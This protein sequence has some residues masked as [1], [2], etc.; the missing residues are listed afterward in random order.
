MGGYW[1]RLLGI[2]AIF[3]CIGCSTSKHIFVKGNVSD[4]YPDYR[5]LITPKHKFRIVF[6][7]KDTIV[8]AIQKITQDS[9]MLEPHIK[10][11]FTKY[12]LIDVNKIYRKDCLSGLGQGILSGAISG[13]LL[14]GV[15]GYSTVPQDCDPCFIQPHHTGL[16]S[17][18]IGAIIGGLF[19]GIVGYHVGDKI[20]FEVHS[21]FSDK[22]I[23]PEYDIN[24]P[25]FK[26]K[27]TYE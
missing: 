26:K 8:G 9:L 27:K 6:S 16:I 5:K 23:N 19:G 14:L 24:H 11:A 17:G 1:K 15:I 2:A 10:G 21:E 7:T 20:V 12:A 4:E 18:S 25:A 13:F 22:I 3:A